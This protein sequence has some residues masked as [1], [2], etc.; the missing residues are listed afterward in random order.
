[1]T[2][3]MNLMTGLGSIG[4]H[5]GGWRHPR[6]WSNTSMNLEHHIEVA[7][8]AERGL[9]DLL[10]L[11]DG[12][13][14]RQLDKPALFEANSPSDRP[15]NFEPVTLLTAIS[16]HTSQIG[17]LATATT[18][19]EEP[20]LLAR[21]FASLDHLSKGRACWNIV[22]GSYPG[23]SVNFGRD[24]HMPRADRYERSEEFVE[25][26]KGLWNSWAADAFLED[27]ESGRY[28][29]KDKVH[30]LNHVGK[31]LSVKGPLNIARMPQGYPVL[32]L[33][34]QSDQGRELAAKH[35]DCVFAV[36]DNIGAAVAFYDDVKGRL[37]AYGRTPDSLRILPGATVYVGESE[38]EADDVYDELQSLIS[39]AVGVPYLSKLAEMDLSGYDIDGPMPDLSG[40]VVGISSFRKNIASMA[41]REDLTIRQT[42]ERVL[43]S[44]GHVVFK[45]NAV[46]VAD[47][48]EEWFTKGAC[49][50]FNLAA[51]VMPFGLES[52]VDH[53]IP[54]LQRRGLFRTEYTGGT[55]RDN[56]GLATPKNPYFDAEQ[57]LQLS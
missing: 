3:H 6:A 51:P 25:V 15:A 36:A 43:P 20:Y 42:Y 27:K 31:H 28:L 2:R 4:G 10:F 30:V 53:L 39:P 14:V 21:K 12:N 23:D 8:I 38:A 46:Q 29:D 52:I 35:A 49:D 11:A 34:G 57:V 5:L 26:V 13:A 9:F 18:T 32:F 48:M 47:Q 44:M 50:G 40:D 19:Y 33:A 56:M 24:E 7:K 22:T 1:M 54:E 55:L 17:L 41:E 16:Q 37:D 45:G